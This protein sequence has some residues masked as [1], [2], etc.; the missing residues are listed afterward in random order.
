MDKL[1]RIIVR[2]LRQ[3]ARRRAV[4]S[5]D[6]HVIVALI[7]ARAVRDSNIGV[8]DLIRMMEYRAPI[9]TVQSQIARLEEH[10][11]RLLEQT[12]L[13]PGAG[14][15]FTVMSRHD[16]DSDV[17]DIRRKAFYIDGG[18]VAWSSTGSM[19]CRLVKELAREL[20][21]LATADQ[22][23][24]LPDQI[25]IA[26]D[27]A[28]KVRR[29]DRAM[30]ADLLE[31]LHGEA[32]VAC[33][34]DVP[35]TFAPRWLTVD[36]LLLAFRPG[37][38]ATDVLRVLVALAA[39]NQKEGQDDDTGDEQDEDDSGSGTEDKGGRH[40][41]RSGTASSRS[42]ASSLRSTERKTST[43]SSGWSRDKPSGAEVIQPE[44][45]DPAAAN[46][47][48]R[49][50]PVTVETLSGYGRAR[51]WAMDLK[52]DIADYAA[53]RLAWSEM[54]S[55]LLLSGPPGT[56]KTTFARALCNTLQ[57][58][59]VVTSVSTWLEGGH[60]NDVIRRMSKTFEEARALAPAILFIDEI[61]GI[62][63]R[64][65]AEREHADYW[66]T[67]VNKALELLDGVMKAEGVVVI[68]ATNRPEQIEEALRRSG[69]L[70][71]H[72]E[73]PRP[74][75]GTLAE[76]LAHHLGGDAARLTEP[77]A[78][79]GDDVP[80]E[81]TCASSRKGEGEVEDGGSGRAQPV[82]AEEVWRNG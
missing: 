21:V 71:T 73:I 68:G 69:R 35:D 7:L 20:P 9:V 25:G 58:P 54:S 13:L 41:A 56:G 49:R 37:R 10:I 24:C 47:D 39:S 79:C 44:P 45:A 77:A 11:V 38:P 32:G 6:N 67:V 53:R 55:K 23:D 43:S 65:P 12:R 81:A 3:D 66:N 72:I 76:I 51:A 82:L 80:G 64:Q 40:R 46:D 63:K 48:V 19:R 17:D 61:D 52:S 57:V 8:R 30:I 60:L 75:I 31:A 29:I 15:Q 42:T 62:G 22:P 78:A 26:A 1:S 28:L 4:H 2:R 36:D 74:D 59:L 16:D 14:F 70:E 5:L 50:S 27:I 34:A 33:L 18:S